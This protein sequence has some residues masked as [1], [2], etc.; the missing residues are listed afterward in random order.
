MTDRRKKCGH[1]NGW[2]YLH[3]K[4][5]RNGKIIRNWRCAVCR[6]SVRP[7]RPTKD[8]RIVSAFKGGL[9]RRQV[10]RKFGVKMER[11]DKAIRKAIL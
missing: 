8:E 6:K 11:V 4:V 10:G 9:S 2:R 7:P 3:N 5:C 1:P